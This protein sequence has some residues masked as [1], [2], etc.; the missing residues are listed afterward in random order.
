MPR[1]TSKR[2]SNSTTKGSYGKTSTSA[3]KLKLIAGKLHSRW[4]GPFVI[5][6]IFP[7]GAVPHCHLLTFS[8]SLALRE[9]EASQPIPSRPRAELA[10]ARMTPA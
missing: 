6:N 7:H 3:K 5:T 10:K 8:F 4:D 2:L 9:E 1:S